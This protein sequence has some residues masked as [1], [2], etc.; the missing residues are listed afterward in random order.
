MS[1]TPIKKLMYFS[2]ETEDDIKMKLLMKKYGVKGLGLYVFLLKQIYRE[3]YYINFTSEIKE[4][5]LLETGLSENEA[6]EIFD[7]LL[8]KGFI[9]KF[10]YEKHKIITSSKIQKRYNQIMKD[11]KRLC[12]VSEYSLINSE[13]KPINSED[14]PIN[15]EDKPQYS[16]VEYS[17]KENNNKKTSS[18]PEYN[19]NVL[20]ENITI[21]EKAEKEVKSVFDF[22]NMQAE[23]F[24]DKLRKSIALIDKARQNLKTLIINNKFNRQLF[25][26]KLNTGGI[27]KWNNAPIDFNFWF[28]N[29]DN[30][31]KLINGNYDIKNFNKNNDLNNP[32]NPSN[33]N[34]KYPD[35]HTK[36][37]STKLA[38]LTTDKEGKEVAILFHKINGENIIRKVLQFDAD[39]KSKY[40]NVVRNILKAEHNIDGKAGYMYV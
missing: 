37:L 9:D 11:L 40:Q 20:P 31:L 28:S 30:Y 8:Q 21:D 19:P 6:E 13:D 7:F 24:P 35:T 25:F 17:N 10:L 29:T 16:N 33:Y 2:I 15:S 14:K 27:D 3:S 5:I 26:Q 32:L 39:T 12:Q 38:E 36:Y 22:Y 23:I 1:K 18:L 34:I 4:L